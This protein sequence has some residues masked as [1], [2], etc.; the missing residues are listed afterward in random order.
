MWRVFAAIAVGVFPAPSALWAIDNRT[1]GFS[2][3]SNLDQ[4]RAHAASHGW[5]IRPRG[6]QPVD[7]FWIVEETNGML[8][9]CKGKV[10]GVTRTYE[11]GVEAFASLEG[12]IRHELLSG[13]PDITV[14][15]FQSDGGPV[16]LIMALF[17]GD[18]GSQTTVQLQSQNGSTQVFSFAILP[19]VC[20]GATE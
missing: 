9:F 20:E 19:S 18:D 4:A 6:D 17:M 3:G 11:G 1:L 13:P 8:E 10:F 16:S 2:L 7:R 15:Q 14:S 5:Q 12:K